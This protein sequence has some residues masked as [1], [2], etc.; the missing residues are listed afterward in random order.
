MIRLLLTSAKN[1]IGMRTTILNTASLT[2]LDHSDSDPLD[3]AS[4]VDITNN[5]PDL[6]VTKTF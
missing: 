2:A 4:S 6:T 1:S 5:F 3:D